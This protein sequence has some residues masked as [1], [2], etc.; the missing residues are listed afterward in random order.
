MYLLKVLALIA[1]GISSVHAK[2]NFG[3]IN[4]S[5]VIESGSTLEI[6]SDLCVSGTIVN[7]GTLV[8]GDSAHFNYGDGH[9]IDHGDTKLHFTRDITLHS[10]ITLTSNSTL[11]IEHSSCSDSATITISGE[12]HK[13]VFAN[14]SD[15][16][17]IIGDDVTLIFDDLEIVGWHPGVISLGENSQIIFSSSVLTLQHDVSGFNYPLTFRGSE[18]DPSRIQ[19]NGHELGFSLCASGAL[20]VEAGQ[21]LRIEDVVLTQVQETVLDVAA[22]GHIILHGVTVVMIGGT[23]I[24]EGQVTISDV[25]RFTGGNGSLVYS[26][27]ETIHILDNAQLI[28]DSSSF[29]HQP[30]SSGSYVI[31]GH[32]GCHSSGIGPVIILQDASFFVGA[33]TLTLDNLT[34]ISRGQSTIYS[35]NLY[36]AVYGTLAFGDGSDEDTNS[37]LRIEDGVL[38][39]YEMQCVIQDVIGD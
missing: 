31:Q 32:T 7:Q 33:S 9:Y 20:I 1:C 37:T 23:Y 3:D 11:T 5:I 34:L 15:D 24:D 21:Y 35:N 13:I 22:T 18:E 39:L 8:V 2:I 28:I 27:P 4:S 14:E 19:G 38:D 17:L 25:V 10:D 6:A 29:A 30:T 16:Q 12:G 36:D 26:S